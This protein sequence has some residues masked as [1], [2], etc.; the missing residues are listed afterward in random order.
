MISLLSDEQKAHLGHRDIGESHKTIN[1][2]ELNLRPVYIIDG[3]RTPFLKARSGPGPFTPVD[4]AF[5]A[6]GPCWHAS[7][8]RRMRLIKS[9]SAASTSSPT[10]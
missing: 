2:S 6:G 8:S 5:S 4:L 10:R 7:R 9:S 1:H 3:S